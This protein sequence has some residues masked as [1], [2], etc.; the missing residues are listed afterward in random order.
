M[1]SNALPRAPEIE[2]RGVTMHY[3]GSA[4]ALSRID[5][6][7]REGEFLSIVGPSGCGK[8]TLLRLISG[9]QRPS[10]GSVRV[11]GEVVSGTPPELGFM[12]QRDALL[13][14]ATVRENIEVGLE[15]GGY[16]KAGRGER[17]DELL[18][19]TGLREFGDAFPHALSGGMRQRVALA[20][21]L[22]YEPGIFLMDEPFGA[23]DAQTKVLMGQELL[24]IWGRHRKA[25]VFVTHDIEEAVSLSDRV[26][27]M[28]GRP[29][30]IRSNYEI[31]LARPRDARKIRSDARFRDYVHAIWN[32]IVSEVGGPA[33]RAH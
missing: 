30:R 8:S 25:V 33:S 15:C 5:L 29:G 22:A 31:E 26:I 9:L 32:D 4:A 16:A 19:I 28:T 20:R 14:W 7:V 13:P 17:L 23:L 2:M 21:I 1:A 24:D 11:R 10:G 12:F 27:V 3:G 18:A 6:D